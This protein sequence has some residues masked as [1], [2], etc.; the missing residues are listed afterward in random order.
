MF[1]LY[2]WRDFCVKVKNKKIIKFDIRYV[3]YYNG[4]LWEFCIHYGNNRTL[5][6]IEIL[7]KQREVS[8]PQFCKLTALQVKI[9]PAKTIVVNNEFVV[10]DSEKM[11]LKEV[12]ERY[13][14]ENQFLKIDKDFNECLYQYVVNKGK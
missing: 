9:Q 6:N 8:V 13:S 12:T 14:S 10:S 1:F 4:H 3:I 11:L 5:A 7:T 2:C